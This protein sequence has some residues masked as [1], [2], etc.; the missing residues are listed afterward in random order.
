MSAGNV[1]AVM[2]QLGTA[3]ATIQGVRVFDFP[4]KSAQPPFAFVDLPSSV[5]FDLSYARGNDRATFVVVL[6]VADVIDRSARDAIAAYAAGTGTTSVKAVID[7]ATV[8][9]SARVTSCEFRPVTLAAGT[10]AG[11]IFDVDVVL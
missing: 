10:Y 11:C 8:G 6:A 7:A 1:G 2:D 5:E 3:L 4:P 9:V